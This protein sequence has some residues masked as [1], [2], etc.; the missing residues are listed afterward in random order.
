MLPLGKDVA[1][2]VGEGI[3]E[4]AY[5]CALAAVGTAAADYAACPSVAAIAHTQRAVDESLKRCLGHRTVY[6][7]YLI[8]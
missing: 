1:V 6:P 5:L 2:P 3:G 7:G 8:E 4:A